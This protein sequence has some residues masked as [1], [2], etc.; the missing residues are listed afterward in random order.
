VQGHRAFIHNSFPGKLADLSGSEYWQALVIEQV[1]S[2]SERIPTAGRQK[3]QR[4]KAVRV[5]KE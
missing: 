4:N 5:Q 3:D 1:N 2:L